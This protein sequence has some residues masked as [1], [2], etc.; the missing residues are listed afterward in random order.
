MESEWDLQ[1]VQLKRNTVQHI[2]KEEHIDS[3]A[4]VVVCLEFNQRQTSS[5]SQWVVAPPARRSLTLG[6]QRRRC[7]SSRPDLSAARQ[8]AVWFPRTS[9]LTQ[10]SLTVTYARGDSSVREKI[11]A[12]AHIS[13]RSASAEATGAGTIRKSSS[14][15]LQ[16]LWDQ[17]YQ[18]LIFTLVLSVNYKLLHHPHSFDALDATQNVQNKKKSKPAV[19]MAAASRSSPG[20][21]S[22]TAKCQRRLFLHRQLKSI[23][24]DAV[25]P[26]WSLCWHD[27][28]VCV[29]LTDSDDDSNFK[30]K[31]QQ[32]AVRAG[33]MLRASAS[34]GFWQIF[35]TL[36]LVKRRTFW[37][38]VYRRRAHTLRKSSN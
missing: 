4:I 31:F 17:Q 20:V 2:S 7:H 32:T 6:R 37:T 12:S 13:L 15:M 30:C 9:L 8:A 26:T 24:S 28:D 19:L 25:V 11:C 3:S 14:T 18:R 38:H 5:M 10:G 16:I 29:K 22:I 23:S 27:D 1:K 36:D 33:F 21:Q 35:R 34:S